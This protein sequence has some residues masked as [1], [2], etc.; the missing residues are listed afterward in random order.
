MNIIYKDNDILVINK[1]QGQVVHPGA[2]G[3]TD[4]VYDELI[5][6][7]D[8]DEHFKNEMR[9]G[10]VHRLDKET[11][12]VMVIARNE[13][14]YNSL[15]NQ[16]KEHNVKKI[17]TSL[18]YGFFNLRSK[19]IALNIGRSLSNRKKFSVKK[20]NEG[21]EAYTEYSVDEMF[22]YGKN[23]K[24]FFALL[25]VVIKTGRT[26]QIRVHL[27]SDG[28]PV[29][30]DK[31]YGKNRIKEIENYGLMLEARHLEF[32]HPTSGETMKFDIGISERFYKVMDILKKL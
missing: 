23:K 11:S 30:N 10:I 4:T 27:S 6:E 14:A 18:N 15:V 21:K 31:V 32:L 3:E 28:H 1:P 2:G 20:Q 9:M 5:K 7:F 24:K 16:F 25:S 26:H 19:V 22:S 17:Y 29:I 8:F 12:G 13:N